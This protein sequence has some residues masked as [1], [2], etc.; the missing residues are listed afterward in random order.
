MQTQFPFGATVRDRRI[1]NQEDK[2][3]ARQGNGIER[4]EVT[5][6]Q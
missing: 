5:P 3:F 2:V 6:C 1:S 4:A